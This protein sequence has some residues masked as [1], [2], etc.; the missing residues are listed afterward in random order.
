MNIFKNIFQSINQHAVI[1]NNVKDKQKKYLEEKEVS[2]CF[3]T[4]SNAIS[5]YNDEFVNVLEIPGNL[6]IV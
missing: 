1:I 5:L 6:F 4:L 2:D 3:L